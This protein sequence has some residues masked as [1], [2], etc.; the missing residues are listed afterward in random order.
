MIDKKKN[1]RITK[2]KRDPE[3][4]RPKQKKNSGAD[5]QVT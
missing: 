2:E 5:V 1:Q 3:I 4:K